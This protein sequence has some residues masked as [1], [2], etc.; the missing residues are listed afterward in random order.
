MKNVLIIGLGQ[1]ARHYHCKII[2]QLSK[3]LGLNIIGVVDLESESKN[4][5]KYLDDISLKLKYKIF[6][7]DKNRLIDKLP[8]EIENLLNNIHLKDKIDLVVISTEPKAHKAYL[9][10]AI[11]N[12]IDSM[13]DKPIS[14][15]ILDT[16]NFKS[17]QKLLDDYNELIN[18]YNNSSSEVVV[19]THRRYCDAYNQM[20]ESAKKIVKETGVPIT[21]ISFHIAEGIWNM[22]FEFLSRENHP[23]KYGYGVLLHSGYHFIDIY[24]LLLRLN[25]FVLNYKT[26][27]IQLTASSVNVKNFISQIPIQLY[28]K[29]CSSDEINRL[30]NLYSSN[31]LDNM[32]ELDAISNITV[33]YD[34]KIVTTSCIKLIQTSCSKRSWYELP[35]DLYRCNGRTKIELINIHFGNV[36][37]LKV[38]YESGF[39]AMDDF[40]ITI[41]RNNKLI[42]GLEKEIIIIPRNVIYQIGND[43]YQLNLGSAARYKVYEEFL[44]NCKNKSNLNDHA[45]G[46][47]I[48]AKMYESIFKYNCG[49]NSTVEFELSSRNKQ[50][51][52]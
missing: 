35:E 44:L 1:Y 50:Y 38:E 34:D 22:P 42:G 20:I 33:K 17:S 51:E 23:Y 49:I 43:K 47:T 27:K 30:E 4:I 5:N 15:C 3:I 41:Y 9:L 12:N 40:T 25:D 36:A 24:N 19:F 6:L 10:W 39:N 46:V 11:N 28:T 7:D 8:S 37:H 52:K 32:G 21:H 14:A 18:A 2:N 31:E 13:V 26:K 48:L 16:T 45:D 29:I